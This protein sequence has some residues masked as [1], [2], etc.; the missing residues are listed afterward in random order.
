MKKFAL[1]ILA[2]CMSGSLW[3]QDLIF[4]RT[5]DSLEVKVLEVGVSEIRY[6]RWSN[7]QGPLYVTNKTEVKRIQ[8]LKGE[9]DEF[10]LMPPP[11]EILE[12]K[13]RN[14]LGN[15][16]EYYP[17]G[18]GLYIFG[19]TGAVSVELN[20]YVV[21]SFEAVIGIG[22]GGG[23]GGMRFHFLGGKEKNSSLYAG[24]FFNIG[25]TEWGFAQANLY[26]PLGVEFISRNGFYFAPEAALLLINP[27]RTP[28][29]PAPFLGFR[30]GIRFSN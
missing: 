15:P 10:P 24:G 1:F 14:C 26:A 9:A 7:L 8:Y 13:G 18:V 28:I 11:I 25:R 29:S 4:F 17:L 21:P 12:S 22:F 16:R 3:A 6:R 27:L 5:G 30:G 2:V 20:Y 19:P 23:Y